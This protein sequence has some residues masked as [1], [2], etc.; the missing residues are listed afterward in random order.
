[1]QPSKPGVWFPNWAE[2]LVQERLPA[3]HRT[4][5]RQA[6]IA[7]L[8]FCKETRQRTTV[9]SARQFMTRMES[10][11]RLSVSQLATWKKALNWFFKEAKNQGAPHLA[12]PAR[13]EVNRVV[14]ARS[15]PPTFSKPGIKD[16]PTL[17]AADL[18]Q[19]DWEQKLVRE[20]RMRHYQW[21][22]EQTYRGW[23][24][25][26]ARWLERKGRSVEEANEEDIRA[27]LSELATH[28]R[29]SAS[30]QKQGLNALVFLVREAL[31]KPLADFS[32]YTRA[33]KTE[34][35]PV[36]LSREECQRLFAAL[37]GTTRLMAEL[38]YGAG[39][40]L[41]ELIGLRIKD[42]VKGFAA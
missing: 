39:L 22:T 40:R 42:R 21:R 26:F 35:L 16:V 6:I 23:A 5:Y 11:R 7:Y 30:T 31:Q 20:L 3:I 14:A 8:R 10:Q 32:D 36:V 4:Q 41:S 29:V 24:V 2:I 33:K 19:T 1:M 13:G 18:G 15:S 34:R 17:G 25:K 9:E 28:Q 38:M 12:S 37:D 27:F